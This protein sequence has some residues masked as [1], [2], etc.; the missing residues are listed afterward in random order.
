MEK[1]KLHLYSD[2]LGN[3]TKLLGLG[4]IP[5]ERIQAAAEFVDFSRFK[6]AVLVDGR[7]LANLVVHDVDDH[8]Y[9]AQALEDRPH[10]VQAMLL[11]SFFSEEEI[12]ALNKNASWELRAKREQEQFEKAEKV[13]EEEYSGPVSD[14]DNYWGSVE[15]YRDQTEDEEEEIRDYLWACEVKPT[16]LLDWQKV[17]EMTTEDETPEYFDGSDI[18]GLE[19]LK[20]AVDAFN[21]KNK[22]WTTWQYTTKIAVI[23]NKSVDNS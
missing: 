11:E 5:D 2:I 22:G 18:K 17:R 7:K 16:V 4:I 8:V 1:K 19:E 21:E 20:A 10:V 12:D 6:P 15:E 9:F 3:L 23:L 14:D 13:P